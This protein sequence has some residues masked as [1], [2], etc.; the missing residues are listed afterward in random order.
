[1]SRTDNERSARRKARIRAKAFS[2]GERRSDRLLRQMV[3]AAEEDEAVIGM[4]LSDRISRKLGPKGRFLAAA[5]LIGALITAASIYYERRMVD[6]AVH[7]DWQ[8]EVLVA[9]GHKLYRDNC[10][11]CHGD[12]LEGQAGW[13]GDFPSGNR[14]G[15]P[16]DGTAPIWRLSDDDIFDVIKYGGQPFSPRSYRNNMPGFE[17]QLADPGI[18]AL[19]AFLKSRWPEDVRQRQAKLESERGVGG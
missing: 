6:T 16:L 1:M 15:L 2:G 17:I 19:V 12:S 5:T 8:D 3:D 4:G 10:A 7:A 18:W 11:F 13:D 9:Q 14:P